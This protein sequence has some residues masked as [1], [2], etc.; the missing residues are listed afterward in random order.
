MS[1][2]F[3]TVRATRTYLAMESPA[4]LQVPAVP[5]L[6][7]DIEARTRCTV[8]EYR[9]LYQLVGDQWEWHDRNDLGDDALAA[10][11]ARSAVHVWTA[12]VGHRTAGF[13]ELVEDED[14]GVEIAYFGL[15][16]GFIGQGL[17]GALLARAVEVAWR[18]S[19]RRVWLHTCSLDAPQALPNYLARGFCVVREESYDARVRAR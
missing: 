19:A 12:R 2:A 5:A 4:A 13:F 3:R 6:R 9:R 11:L 15:L 14:A 10:H 7:L 8:A 18:L 16:P 1:V 17:G